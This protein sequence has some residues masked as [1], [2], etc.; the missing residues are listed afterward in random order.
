MTYCMVERLVDEVTQQHL[1]AIPMCL[2][3]VVSAYQAAEPTSLQR[4]RQ[5]SSAASLQQL[6]K[7]QHL[8]LC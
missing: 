2:H 5:R 1:P 4:C 6:W 3:S 8:Q 7:Q